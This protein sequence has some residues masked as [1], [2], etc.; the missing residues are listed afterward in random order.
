MTDSEKLD[1]MLEKMTSLETKMRS[2]KRQQTK[3]TSE[4]KPMNSI[5]FD[6][7]ERVYEIIIKRTDELQKKSDKRRGGLA[8]HSPLQL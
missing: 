4:L 2:L 6:E 3:D 7:I 5:I 8:C 1:L